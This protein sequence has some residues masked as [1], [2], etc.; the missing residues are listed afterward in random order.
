MSKRSRTSILVMVVALVGGFGSGCSIR[1]AIC[2][3]GQYPVAAVASYTG[4]A[5]VSDGEPP[6]SGFVR[7]PQGKEPK[8]VGDK[9]DRY[10]AEHRLDGQG[11]EL[12]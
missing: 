9:W 6:P 2:G 5:C 8:Q 7:F 10:W 12:A 11:R 3:S 4:R 1:E